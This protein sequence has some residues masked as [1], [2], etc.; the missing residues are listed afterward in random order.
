MWVLFVKILSLYFDWPKSWIWR[1]LG[2][3]MDIFRIWHFHYYSKEV[4]W[5]KKLKFVF[6]FKS[7]ILAIFN[8]AKILFLNFYTANILTAKNTTFHGVMISLALPLPLGPLI[9]VPN[10]MDKL[11]CSRIFGTKFLYYTHCSFY[12]QPV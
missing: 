2:H 9:T 11:Y 3:V 5:Q 7:A 10:T 8:T 12:S 4:F 6:W 1:N